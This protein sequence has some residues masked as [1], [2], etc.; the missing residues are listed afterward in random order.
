MMMN[1]KSF[2]QS[3]VVKP[4]VLCV[5]LQRLALMVSHIACAHLWAIHCGR[6]PDCHV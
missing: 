3:G 1:A 4:L 5:L 6:Q 2:K